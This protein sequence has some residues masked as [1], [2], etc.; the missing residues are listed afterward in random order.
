M[1]NLL[2]I[3][4]VVLLGSCQKENIKPNYETPTNTERTIGKNRVE[5]KLIFDK[6]V[7]GELNIYV[8]QNLDTTINL[9]DLPLIDTTNGN[10]NFKYVS[11]NRYY[12]TERIRNA[13]GWLYLDIRFNEPTDVFN[14]NFFNGKMTFAD[15]NALLPEPS[16]A[17]ANGTV[18]F[19]NSIWVK[20]PTNTVPSKPVAVSF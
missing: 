16:T 15:E 14:S 5:Y 3:S 13:S 11:V 7:S 10:G 20:L 1:K 4:L 17:S 19:Y 8:G 9:S 12:S 2:F 18:S 6:E